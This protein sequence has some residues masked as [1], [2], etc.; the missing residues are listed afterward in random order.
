MPF[1]SRTWS[2][3]CS[4]GA[5]L[6]LSACTSTIEPGSGPGSGAGIGPTA[7]NT[8]GGGLA[9]GGRPGG[10]PSGGGA[11]SNPPSGGGQSVSGGAGGANP[12]TGTAG[13]GE[14]PYAIPATPPTAALVA[15]PRLARLSRQ[16][17]S[18]TVRDLLKVT[19]IAEIDRGVSGDALVRFDNEADA[20]YVGEMLRREFATAAEKLADK[21]TAGTWGFA[22]AQFSKATCA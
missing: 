6:C 21:V 8:A 22:A 2:A 18:N 19:D 17:W 5:L 11:T 14:D 4:L 12:P 13:T 7:G 10:P 9:G 16:Q 15:T 3:S 20:L 1:R